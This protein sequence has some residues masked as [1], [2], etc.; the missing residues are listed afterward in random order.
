MRKDFGSR[1]AL[2]SSEAVQLVKEWSSDN[3]EPNRMAGHDYGAGLRSGPNH[4]LKRFQPRC[5]HVGVCG[6]G[7]LTA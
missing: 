6:M 5:L 7:Q 3:E 4:S 2:K 1:A